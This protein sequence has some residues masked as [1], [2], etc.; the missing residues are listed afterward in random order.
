MTNEWH[1]Y[2]G[3]KN[4]LSYQVWQ[5]QEHLLSYSHVIHFRWVGE[6][7]KLC[8]IKA[9]CAVHISKVKAPLLLQIELKDIWAYVKV[10]Y[11]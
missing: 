8:H 2:N 3:Q 7:K 6:G 1:P 11:I 5:E 4:A 10:I 9:G